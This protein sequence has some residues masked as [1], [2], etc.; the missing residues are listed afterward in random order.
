VDTLSGQHV[1][2]LVFTGDIFDSNDAPA[3][4]I[5]GFLA[6]YDR[7]E[8]ALGPRVPTLLIPG[9]HDRRASGVFTPWRGELFN[10]LQAR[11]ATRPHVRV[12]GTRA[13]YLADLIS[14]PDLPADVVAYDSTYLP[15]GWLSAGGVVRQEDILQ[16]ASRLT[17]A[18]TRP[19]LFLLHHHLVPTPVTDVSLIH[20]ADRPL[21]QQLLVHRLLPTLV[22]NGNR[23]ELTMTAL[24]A[25]SALT[26]LHQLGRPIVVMHGHKHYPTARLLTGM[27]ADEGD[28]L[29]TSAGSCG[30]AE[31]FEDGDFDESP[32]LWPS[33]NFVELDGPDISVTTQAWSP[34]EAHRRNTPRTLARV[35]Q[36]GARFTVQPS[37]PPPPF[38]P[39]LHENLAVMRMTESS[40]FLSR[41]DVSVTRSIEATQVA[42]M[43]WYGEAVTGPP[44]A[45]VVNFTAQGL[46]LPD[47]P[48]PARLQLPM[49]GEA[50][51]TVLGG[52]AA[53]TAG[54]SE[55]A[56]EDT[57]CESVKLH[58]RSRAA[59]A[60]LTLDLGTLPL[61]PFGS[62][63]DLTTGRERPMPLSREGNRVTLEYRQCPA[64]M[65]LR[66]SWPVRVE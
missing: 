57:T 59:V 14:L 65:L 40:R 31:R 22:G 11:F 17:S 43:P 49:H 56:G 39:V 10:T 7:L 32:R 61:E 19:L 58:N 18:P 44:G 42:F 15:Q 16:V 2:L 33:I 36:Q 50:S 51:F 54:A 25:G 6:L 13:P 28:V 12:A 5:D 46:P 9:N 20:T 4:L 1:D 34:F 47:A 37:P 60:R 66:I 63:L 29:L 52:A 3:P 23:E 48:C 26:T 45:R 27:Q 35:T 24:G 62:A 53:T 30:L 21:L 64:R 8:Q 38:E 55:H 41:Y